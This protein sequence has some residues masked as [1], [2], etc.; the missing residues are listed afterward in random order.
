MDICINVYIYKFEF[1]SKSTLS[2]FNISLV[3]RIVC[4]CGISKRC[5][6]QISLESAQSMAQGHAPT[7]DREDCVLP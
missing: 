6:Q 3:S 2:S 7:R 4:V 1:V 5:Y